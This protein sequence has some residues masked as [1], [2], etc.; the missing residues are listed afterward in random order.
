MLLSG[1]RMRTDAGMQER[2]HLCWNGRKYAGT[3]ASMRP[4]DCLLPTAYCLLLYH[5]HPQNNISHLQLMHHFHPFGH[6]TKVGVFGIKMWC[7]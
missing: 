7:G 1:Q 3:D 4:Y 5:L 2:T 6:K